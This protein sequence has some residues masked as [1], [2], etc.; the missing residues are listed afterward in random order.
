ME[1]AKKNIYAEHGQ[2]VT[3]TQMMMHGDRSLSPAKNDSED[4]TPDESGS[5]RNGTGQD[6]ANEVLGQNLEKVTSEKA[7]V[8][9][10]LSL[11][12]QYKRHSG[13]AT[14]NE[15]GIN[16]GEGENAA[17][18]S[19]DGEDTGDNL[20]TGHLEHGNGLGKGHEVHGNGLG[21]GHD[22]DA[23]KDEREGKDHAVN[24]GKG[25]GHIR[26]GMGLGK[27]HEHHG[28]GLGLG[29]DKHE[30]GLHIFHTETL[31]DADISHLV[32]ILQVN[33]NGS[34]STVSVTVLSTTQHELSY[35]LTL[36]S[37]PAASVMSF[38]DPATE[39]VVET[40]DLSGLADLVLGLKISEGTA[41]VILEL[42]DITGAMS[43]LVLEDIGTTEQ[44]YQV[45][46]EKVQGIDLAQVV[47]ISLIVKTGN[48]ETLSGIL[49]VRIGDL[50]Y[51]IS[52]ATPTVEP[53]APTLS[54]KATLTGTKPAGS[55]IYIDG[56]EVV[57]ADDS[58]TW[59]AEVALD[60]GA[61][62][63]SVTAKIG[64]LVSDPLLVTVE[65]LEPVAKPT[66][67]PVAPT[68]S[69][70][71]TLTGTK[72]AG[73]AIYIDGVEVV[74]ADDSTTWSAE[75]ALDLGANEFSVTAKI[76]NLV[77]DPLLVTVERLEPV[78]KPT[79]EQVAP[80]LLEKATLTGTK[81][82]GSAIY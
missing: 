47:N 77:S 40:K 61:N 12:N 44:F 74:P 56:V 5:P 11:D 60:L 82:A 37:D 55:A 42:Q 13:I 6:R 7:K 35:D 10:Q 69:E 57:P 51:G 28:N 8:G 76:G 14:P 49:S 50:P 2:P 31:T 46:L 68:L 67:E 9:L 34:A 62:E 3:S 78:A 32:G 23:E 33:G 52:V 24:P 73:S 18:S 53:V 71:A 79:V 41:N 21:L 19:K 25:M 36:A 81:P 15:E 72:P 30:C 29:H 70:K 63:F 80:T 1:T 48:T 20:G 26:H 59:S 39:D 54:E 66:V 43:Y 27:G 17:L 58:T 65:R 22:P 75:V 64:D 38:D 16:E 45:P 4:P